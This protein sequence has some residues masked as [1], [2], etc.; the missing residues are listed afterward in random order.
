MVHGDKD[1]TEIY[2]RLCRAE[3]YSAPTRPTMREVY[4]PADRADRG[5]ASC[6]RS[7]RSVADSASP[8]YRHLEETGRRLMGHRPPAGAKPTGSGQICR[9]APRPHRQI[10]IAEHPREQQKTG[11]RSLEGRNVSTHL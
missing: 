5:P 8:A 2:A 1:V 3:G 11:P 7:S 6:W 4:D 10:G 9:S